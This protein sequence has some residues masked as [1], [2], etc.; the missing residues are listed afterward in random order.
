MDIY[1]I[2]HADAVALGENNV[3]ADADRPLTEVGKG[4]AKAVAT[5]LQRKGVAL[6]LILTSP[7]L[8]ARQ[9]AEGILQAWSGAPPE[10]QVCDQLTPG[11]RPRKLAK[12]LKQF[13]REPVA[14]IG[15][16]PDLSAWAAWV[17]G[18][19]KAQL[20]LAKAGVAHLTCP[21]GPGKGAGTLVQ[22]LTPDWLG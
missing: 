19:K 12:V 6:Q 9:T 10:V 14:L 16:E 13:K 2:R 22:L 15:H 3:N 20:A 17:I 21:D 1:V 18:G 7:L 4:Q 8:R 5:G 11:S